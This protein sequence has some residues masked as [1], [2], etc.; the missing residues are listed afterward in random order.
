MYTNLNVLKQEIIDAC[1]ALH[2]R[3]WGLVRS[4]YYIKTGATRQGYP[5]VCL[6]SAWALRRY[7]KEVAQHP[8][9]QRDLS[10][11]LHNVIFTHLSSNLAATII[12]CFD[13][14]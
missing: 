11:A 4:R 13:T 3:K 8:E 2:Q 6:L 7:P 5:E 12:T 14:P 1:L 10:L 9:H